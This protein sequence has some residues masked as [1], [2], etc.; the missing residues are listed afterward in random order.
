[1]TGPGVTGR[2]SE[3]SRDGLTFDVRDEGPLDGDPVVLLHGFPE[4][5]TCWRHVAPLLHEQGLRTLAPDQR[6]YSPRA[7]PRGRRAY[8]SAELVADVAALVDAVGRPVHLVGHDWGAIVSWAFAATHPEQLRSMTVLSVPHPRAFLRSL[9]GRQA[10]K[11]WYMLA[12]QL[13]FVPERLAPEGGFFDESMRASGKS[14]D[15]VQRFRREVVDS[16]ALG[17]ALGW[18]RAMPFLDRRAAGRRI[19]TPTTLVWSDGD[20]FVGRGGVDRTPPYVDAPYELVV[21]PGV[22]HWIPTEAPWATADAV[23]ARIGSVPG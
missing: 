19:T 18:Y 2:I 23:L 14:R 4:T 9:A 12:F 13:P 22:S 21:L 20:D 1:M 5:S 6:G 3:Y 15:D 11:S 10:L 16:G 7:R 8:R 17:P